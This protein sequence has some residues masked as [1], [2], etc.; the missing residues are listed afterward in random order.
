MGLI[1]ARYEPVV[2][3]VEDGVERLCVE[4]AVDVVE[5]ELAHERGDEH[6]PHKFAEPRESALEA[7]VD[8][9]VGLHA[10]IE[11]EGLR[12]P[13]EARVAKRDLEGVPYLSLGRLLLLLLQFMA[14]R[15]V[16]EGIWQCDE[17]RG[18]RPEAGELH[19]HGGAEMNL[20]RRVCVQ[21]CLPEC[22]GCHVRRMD[23]W[24]V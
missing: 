9:A 8:V 3:L 23:V 1:E 13:Y 2:R 19:E 22:C 24:V 18:E 20:V 16:G 21:E 5:E 7:H 6:L 15:E 17:E 10:A 4:E 14:R 11:L 12:G